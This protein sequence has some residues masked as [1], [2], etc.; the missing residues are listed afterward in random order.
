MDLDGRFHYVMPV[1][2]AIL[3]AISW[4][5]FSARLPR[6]TRLPFAGWCALRLVAAP[7]QP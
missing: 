2:M 3:L 6:P 4:P 7:R 5:S 1:P